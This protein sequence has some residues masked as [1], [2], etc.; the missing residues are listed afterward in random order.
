MSR[1]TH[2]LVI[3]YNSSTDWYSKFRGHKTPNGND[4]KVE[5][6][7]W[8]QICLVGNSE[9]GPILQLRPN[10]DGVLRQQNHEREFIPDFVLIRNFP[11]ALHR[12]SYRNVLL[13]LMFCGIPA[14]NSLQAVFNCSEKPVVYG[15]LKKIQKELGGYE[16]FPLIP[17]IYYPNIQTCENFEEKLGATIP[18]VYPQVVKSKMIEQILFNSSWNCS[19]WIW[20][21]EI[22]CKIRF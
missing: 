7:G 17:Q 20:K 4:I 2:L 13:G 22:K 18:E 5:Q 15:A 12:T 1:T 10:D 11:S 21:D 6:A 3:D 14:I 9:C 8:A 19:R 16:K